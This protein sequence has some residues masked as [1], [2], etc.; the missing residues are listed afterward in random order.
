MVGVSPQE[1]EKGEYDRGEECVF[2]GADYTSRDAAV[3]LHLQTNRIIH[4]RSFRAFPNQYPFRK[5]EAPKSDKTDAL[6]RAVDEVLEERGMD[7]VD[8]SDGG[9]SED[10]DE[11]DEE[12]YED[13]YHSERDTDSDDESDYDEHHE[14]HDEHDDD[15]YVPGLHTD[16]EPDTD[17]DDEDDDNEHK[18]SSSISSNKSTS[19]EEEDDNMSDEEHER[20]RT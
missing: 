16:S 4:R 18:H 17:S 6:H 7:D 10:D 3:L 1:L 11:K 14:E 15:D 19:E 13:H 12:E 2:L 5:Q 8:V 9:E 20:R